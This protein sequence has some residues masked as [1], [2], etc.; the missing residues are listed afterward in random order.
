MKKSQKARSL[1]AAACLAGSACASGPRRHQPPKPEECPPG[2]AEIHKRFDIYGW[3]GVLFPPFK[4]EIVPV[5]EG[6]IITKIIGPWGALEDDTLF[7]G[8]VFF[9]KNRVYARFTQVRLPTGEMLPICLEMVRL[10]DNRLHRG[11]P[12]EPGSTSDRALID[13]SVSVVPVDRFE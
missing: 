13:S 9:G 11:L 8:R 7:F 10:T 1:A 4:V 3:H 2:A 6:D 12:M 5:R